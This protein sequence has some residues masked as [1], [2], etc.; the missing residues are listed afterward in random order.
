[1][2]GPVAFRGTVLVAR[3]VVGCSP[4]E[5]GKLTSFVAGS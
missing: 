3:I 1:L 5:T 2:V 4:R